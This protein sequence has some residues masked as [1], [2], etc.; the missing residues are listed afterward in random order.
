MPYYFKYIYS[1]SGFSKG[2]MWFY[3]ANIV[4]GVFFHSVDRYDEDSE[5]HAVA[6][7]HKANSTPLLAEKTAEVAA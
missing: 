6:G 7:A 3:L 2:A 4:A 5:H 1:F